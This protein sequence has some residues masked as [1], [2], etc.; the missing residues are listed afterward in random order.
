MLPVPRYGMP[1]MVF[2][3][4]YDWRLWYWTGNGT[5]FVAVALFACTG[6]ALPWIGIGVAMDWFLALFDPLASIVFESWL[7][8]FAK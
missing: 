4:G 7:E 3:F 1:G 2:C 8:W 5:V 6:L